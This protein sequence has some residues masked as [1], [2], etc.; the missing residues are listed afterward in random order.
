MARNND[1]HPSTC[2]F[3]YENKN[4]QKG[5]LSRNQIY[6]HSTYIKKEIKRV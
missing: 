4:Q 1:Y 2:N 5:F 6:L 3:M